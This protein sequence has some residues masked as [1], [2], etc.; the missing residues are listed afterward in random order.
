[1]PDAWRTRSLV[2]KVENTRVSHHRF[3]ETIRHSLHDGAT[4][5]FAISPV[6]RA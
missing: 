6:C 3:A 4:V 2:C 1:M 5:Y